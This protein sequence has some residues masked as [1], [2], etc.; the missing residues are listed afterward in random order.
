M[1]IESVSN[2]S[3]AIM[4]FYLV[5][6]CNFT[7]ETLGCNLQYILRTNIYAKH[8]VSIV[9]MLFLVIF[10]NPKEA[11]KD[12]IV[13][14]GLSIVVYFWFL[15][16]CRCPLFIMIIVLILLMVIYI[17]N[18][19]KSRYENEN[20]NVKASQVDRLQK[21]IAI[22]A[23]VFSIIGFLMYLFE[24]YYEYGDEFSIVK[25]ITG[26]VLCRNYTPSYLRFIK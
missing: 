18:A 10:V 5:V 11:D 21:I 7:A 14:I 20:N 1:F 13:K 4:A 19:T 12:I 24:K 2:V 23:F 22:I 16:T 26:D 25:F 3:L 8:I 9:L 17:I 15:I 6:F